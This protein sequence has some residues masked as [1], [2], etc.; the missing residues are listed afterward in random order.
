V[1]RCRLDV[2]SSG[3]GPVALSYEHSNEPLDSIQGGKLLI[4]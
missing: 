2:Y 3:Q 1:K 4:S